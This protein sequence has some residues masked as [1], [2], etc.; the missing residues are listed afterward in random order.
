MVH[1]YSLPEAYLTFKNP[2]TCCWSIHQ[3]SVI[4]KCFSCYFC[5]KNYSKTVVQNT[6]LLYPSFF[7]PGVQAWW[8]R[9][10]SGS[11]PFMRLQSRHQQ[12]LPSFQGSTGEGSTSSLTHM[13]VLAGIRLSL[14]AGYRCCHLGFSFGQLTVW[15]PTSLRENWKD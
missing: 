14:A 2:L 11:V 5:V 15:Q 3:Y 12:W 10:P 13:V 8:H 7:G 6:H 9:V 1:G 4:R